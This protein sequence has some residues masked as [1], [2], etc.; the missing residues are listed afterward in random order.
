MHTR[1]GIITP[2]CAGMIASICANKCVDY[3]M[4]WHQKHRNSNIILHDST[5]LGLCS[6]G[7]IVRVC[8]CLGVIDAYVCGW[9]CSKRACVRIHASACLC[10]DSHAGGMA[11]KCKHTCEHDCTYMYMQVKA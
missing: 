1:A 7:R 3:T 4:F 5:T 10:V 9:A 11:L 6:V 2:M 8:I